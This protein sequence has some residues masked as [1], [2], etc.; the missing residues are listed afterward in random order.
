MWEYASGCLLDDIDA[1]AGRPY[2]VAFIVYPYRKIGGILCA[3]VGPKGRASKNTTVNT[4]QPRILCKRHDNHS[5]ALAA[6]RV[7]LPGAPLPECLLQVAL[8]GFRVLVVAALLSSSSRKCQH[9][10]ATGRQS[11]PYQQV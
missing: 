1:T 7:P 2:V 4:P 8:L 10:S 11:C 9:S 6:V 3:V 5:Q